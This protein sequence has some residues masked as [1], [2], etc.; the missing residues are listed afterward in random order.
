[1]IPLIQDS[2]HSQTHRIEK[3]NS[4]CQML[5]IWGKWKLFVYGPN[6]SVKQHD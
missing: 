2:L 4:D 6:V 3:W 1:M 5:G